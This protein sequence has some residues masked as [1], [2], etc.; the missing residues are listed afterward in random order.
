[1]ATAMLWTAAAGFAVAGAAKVAGFAV[2]LAVAGLYFHFRR[3][4]TFVLSLVTL[5][6]IVLFSSGYVV[7][8][9]VGATTAR[10]FADG[11]LAGWDAALGFHAAD[12][13][14]WQAHH[15]ALGAVLV[16]AYDTLLP[17]TA[18]LVIILGLSGDRKPLELFVLRMILAGLVTLAFFLAMPAEGPFRYYGFTPSPVQAHYLEHLHGLR[19]GARA[20]FSFSDAEGLI[21]FPSFHTIWAIL[22]TVACLHRRGVCVFLR[23]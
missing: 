21:T 1:M 19:S 7:L 22:L 2:L 3:E 4:E 10:P 8:T 23:D 20:F 13:V 16:A 17:Q 9:Y 15:P 11:L 5:L 18:A 14:A 6:Q 12:A